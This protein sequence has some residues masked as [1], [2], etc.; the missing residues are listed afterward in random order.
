MSLYRTRA[1]PSN[2]ARRLE[3]LQ[4]SG[5]IVDRLAA[6]KNR[7]P[8]RKAASQDALTEALR[9]LRSYRARLIGA[10]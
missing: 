9:L 6:L 10:E 8:L 4:L 2:E 3:K 7:R 1:M 5:D